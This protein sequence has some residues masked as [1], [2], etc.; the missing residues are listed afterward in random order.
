VL[1]VWVRGNN[2]I[3]VAS[4]VVKFSNFDFIN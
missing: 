3:E 1:L 4:D 2:E